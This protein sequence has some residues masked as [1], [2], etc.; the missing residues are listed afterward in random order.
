MVREV[1][2]FSSS[3]LLSAT[4]IQNAVLEKFHVIYCSIDNAEKALSCF[5]VYFVRIF[6]LTQSSSAHRHTFNSK[7]KSPFKSIENI[8]VFFFC[9]QFQSMFIFT[10]MSHRGH[11]KKI[12]GPAKIRKY[13]YSDK[14]TKISLLLPLP[15]INPGRLLAI[16]FHINSWSYIKVFSHFFSRWSS[17]FYYWSI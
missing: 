17:P 14:T 12:F 10:S 4:G 8:E 9:R 15:E 3:S 13:F 16:Y 11:A 2:Q 6:F 7:H 5:N 1:C